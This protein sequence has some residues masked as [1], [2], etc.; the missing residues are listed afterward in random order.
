MITGVLAEWLRFADW[1]ILFFFLG[2]NFFSMMLLI[3]SGF[4]VFHF[5]R[6]SRHEILSVLSF[7]ELLPPIA[8][9]VPAYNEQQTIIDSV[10]SMLSMNYPKYEVVVVNDGSTDGTLDALKKAYLLYP[11]IPLYDEMIPTRP[12]RSLFRSKSHPN[13]IVADKENGGKSDALN[14]AINL[15]SNPLICTVDADTLVEEQA[16]LG[17]VRPFLMDP[18][19]VAAV[20]GTIRVANGCGIEGGR[21]ARVGLSKHWFV[22]IQAVEYIRSFLFGRLG[23]NPLGGPLIVSGA[24]GLFRKDLVIRA[25]G[26]RT[27][28]VGEDMD[29]VLSLHELEMPSRNNSRAAGRPPSRYKIVF[30]PD[31]VCW[32]QAPEDLKTLARQR[33]RWQRGQTESLIHHRRL[34]FSFRHGLIG[35]VGIPYSFFCEML[36]PLLETV[37]YVIVLAGFFLGIVNLQFAFLFFLVAWGFGVILSV[38]AIV[39]EEISFHR[40]SF[41]DVLRLLAAAILEGFGY[42][43]LN[44]WWRLKGLAQF[45]TGKKGW[46]KMRRVEFGSAPSP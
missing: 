13:L 46:G 15:S 28:T 9:L 29:L 16:L 17:M 33:E 5:V 44:F 37:G 10:R 7:S 27:G 22:R 30:V 26:Y 11:V 6:A 14:C 18:G 36:A 12:L 20:G 8:I 19:R 40:Y 41:P 45:L 21:I 1:A 23:W 38:A 39:L 42:R 43:Q 31:T 3:L 34:L 4:G 25:G 2:Q 32:T 35:L 24:F